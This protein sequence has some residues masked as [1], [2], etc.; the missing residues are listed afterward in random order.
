MFLQFWFDSSKKDTVPYLAITDSMQSIWYI[1]LD[2]K[3][4]RI[5]HLGSK[6]ITESSG[7]CA[8]SSWEQ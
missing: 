1:I 5:N 3:Q 4:Q 7:S 8:N 6:Y 2:N